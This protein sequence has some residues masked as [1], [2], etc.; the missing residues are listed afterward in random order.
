MVREV[1]VKPKDAY[2][3]YLNAENNVAN[4]SPAFD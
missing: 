1:V 4:A 2:W 3:S